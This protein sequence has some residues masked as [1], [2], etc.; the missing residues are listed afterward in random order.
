M[1]SWGIQIYSQV[2]TTSVTRFKIQK[3]YSQKLV[4]SHS[5]IK[6]EEWV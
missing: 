3:N 1:V 4:C 5:S 2:A 6:V